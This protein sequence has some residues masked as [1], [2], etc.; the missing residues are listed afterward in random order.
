MVSETEM[1]SIHFPVLQSRMMAL[2]SYLLCD[3]ELP[4]NKFTTVVFHPSTS[5]LLVAG[6]T[7]SGSV[8]LWRVTEDASETQIKSDVV[9]LNVHS[10]CIN[11]LMFGSNQPHFL[12]T[13]SVDGC[14]KYMDL[15]KEEFTLLYKL[16]SKGVS[17]LRQPLEIKKQKKYR[18]SFKKI[19][20]FDMNFKS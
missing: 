6:G 17:I 16:P 1:S 10:G 4:N 2:Q 9:A 12:F 7:K 8:C 5:P 11:Q 3:P 15:N 19:K 20:D 13:N 18:I 14:L